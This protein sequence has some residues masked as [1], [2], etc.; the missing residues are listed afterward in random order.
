MG[1]KLLFN[2]VIKSFESLLSGSVKPEPEPTPEPEPE[3][4]TEPEK[5]PES[6][7]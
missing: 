5:E 2:A 6:V 4:E 3:A 1:N 7:G